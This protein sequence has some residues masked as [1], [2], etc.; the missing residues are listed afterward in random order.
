METIAPTPAP[1]VVPAP[2]ALPIPAGPVFPEGT[3]LR[4]YETNIVLRPDLGEEASEKFRQ[5]IRALI[6]GNG[7]KALK[8]STW[9]RKKLAYLIE[10]HRY[11]VYVHVHYVGP[12]KL[13]AEIERNL[14]N[15]D[16][17]LRYLSVKL[18]DE[19]DANRPAEADAK[20]A[21]DAENERPPREERGGDR[22]D[23]N[24]GDVGGMGGDDDGEGME[25]A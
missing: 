15:T 11:G 3:K 1:A 14:R 24:D 22:R 16:E 4:E 21:G 6:V 12:S 2:E 9:N 5:R 7:G 20:F 17:V 13:V 19:T 10:D 23:D 18:A 25:S 8:F